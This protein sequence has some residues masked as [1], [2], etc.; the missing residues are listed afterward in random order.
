M[1]DDNLELVYE[2]SDVLFDGQQVDY[3]GDEQHIGEG[4][5]DPQILPQ[6]HSIA[7]DDMTV[8]EEDVVVAKAVPGAHAGPFLKLAESGAW[9]ADPYASVLLSGL[10]LAAVILKN[11]VLRGRINSKAGRRGVGGGGG[12]AEPGQSDG[13]AA[14]SSMLP[15]LL[16]HLG[17]LEGALSTPADTAQPP[18]RL[19]LDVPQIVTSS[20]R[21]ASCIAQASAGAAVAGGSLAQGLPALERV[22]RITNRIIDDVRAVHHGLQDPSHRELDYLRDHIGDFEEIAGAIVALRKARDALEQALYVTAKDPLGDAHAALHQALDNKHET[23][24][25]AIVGAMAVFAEYGD[26]SSGLYLEAA[27]AVDDMYATEDDAVR[28]LLAQRE[29]SEMRMMGDAASMASAMLQNGGGGHGNGQGANPF[30][31]LENGA[32]A[33]ASGRQS[34][35]DALDAGKMHAATAPPHHA[36]AFDGTIATIGSSTSI[37]VAINSHSLHSASDSGV[38]ALVVSQFAIEFTKVRRDIVKELDRTLQQKQ[39]ERKTLREDARR[40]AKREARQLEQEARET[41]LRHRSLQE[42]R[43]VRSSFDDEFASKWRRDICARHAEAKRQQRGFDFYYL[44]VLCNL[45]V[46][47]AFGGIAGRCKLGHGW[48][49]QQVRVLCAALS[50]HEAQSYYAAAATGASAAAGGAGAPTMQGYASLLFSLAGQVTG[51]ATLALVKA[52]QGWD[53]AWAFHDLALCSIKILLSILV[54]VLLSRVLALVHRPTA[55]YVLLVGVVWTLWEPAAVVF[56]SLWQTCVVAAC[57]CTIYYALLCPC[58]SRLTWGASD[59][60]VD[61]RGL[62]VY[63]LLPLWLVGLSTLLACQAISTGES[64]GLHIGIRF[65][66]EGVGAVLRSAVL[67]QC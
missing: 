25:A 1:E 5:P 48:L 14:D 28:Q 38:K 55:S 57:N 40:E 56:V 58:D 47:V 20:A 54:P 66:W 24:A 51:R 21:L 12:R 63:F 6:F 53:A 13:S 9:L 61:L 19:H 26:K 4:R 7:L 34:P 52:F 17:D 23:S 16:R 32:T 35:S 8:R 67:R 45:L 62:V 41:A 37:A 30:A 10:L 36:L 39:Q 2:T 11:T 42:Q 46:F 50:H 18:P 65:T 33:A 27:A 15:L 44:V 59:R 43:S 3:H 49:V 64:R 29:Q 31:C 60:T 22:E